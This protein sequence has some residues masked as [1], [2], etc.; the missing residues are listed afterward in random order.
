MHRYTPG[1]NIIHWCKYWNIIHPFR[2]CKI[3]EL[4]YTVPGRYRWDPRCLHRHLLLQHTHTHT[5][6][7]RNT[8]E[9]TDTSTGTSTDMDTDTGRATDIHTETGRGKEQDL[10]PLCSP[11]CISIRENKYVHIHT[12]VFNA[13]AHTFTETH[14][15]SI[16]ALCV[17]HI[18]QHTH[19]QHYIAHTHHSLAHTH[20]RAHTHANLS[21][22]PTS[23]PL[24]HMP[25]LS[26]QP[27][28][29]QSLQHRQ[30]RL[31]TPPP[32]HTLHFIRSRCLFTRS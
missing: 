7:N 31:L 27:L 15:Y 10:N 2:L 24:S 18:H 4:L 28:L 11:V 13:S 23:S 20:T 19:T 17:L 25:S 26:P 22:A 14:A 1:P 8:C 16:F 32:P 3:N 5:H 30:P 21:S 29:H 9:N 6:R 12:Q